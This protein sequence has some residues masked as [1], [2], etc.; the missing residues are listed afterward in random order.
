VIVYQSTKQ[1]FLY[2]SDNR[3]IEEV[4]EK[5]Y[6]QK[7]KRYASHGEFRAWRESLK[8]MAKVLRDEG[9]PPD[10][11]IGIEFGIPQSHKRIDFILS[12]FADDGSP[13]VV[14]VELKQWS[15]T[16]LRDFDGLIAAQR[17]GASYLDGPHPC[18]QAWSYAALLEGFNEAVYEGEV[19]LR[20]CAYLHNHEKDGVVNDSRYD[21]YM[22]RAPLFLKGEEELRRLREFVRKHVRKGDN[23]ELLFKIENGRIRPSKMLADS[24]VSMLRG[25]SDF[26]LIDEQKV[27]YEHALAAAEK[28]SPER[29]QV[30]LIKGGPGTGKSV[31]AIHLLAKL[32]KRGL[33]AKYVSRNAA[34]RAVYQAR[35]TG[36]FRR[37]VIANL[38]G[39]TSVF[40]D[41]EPNV[42]DVLIVD[43]A[44]RLNRKSGLYGNLGEDQIMEIMRS[45]SCSIFFVDDDQ[46]V[47]L[48]D[49]GNTDE[50]RRWAGLIGAEV[51]ELEL[52]SQ[53]R[54]NGSEGFLPW[55]DYLLGLREAAGDHFD[56]RTFEFQVVDSPSQLHELIQERNGANRSRVVAGYCWDW[57][58]K[59]DPGAFDIEIGEYR[60]RWNLTNDGSLWIIAPTSVSEVG[61]IHTCQGLEVDY[62]GVIVGRD[63]LYRSGKLVTAVENRSRMDRSVRGYKSALRSEPQKTA[64]LVDR[65]I[66]NTYRTLMTRGLKGCYIH[67]VDPETQGYFKSRLE[68]LDRMPEAK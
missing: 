68:S 26:V 4:V 64:E 46:A 14:I 5:A 62:I 40:H 24:L 18:Y 29:K 34:P 67:C 65:L 48:S 21:A 42:F 9:I 35:L 56:R 33:M 11:G 23:G 10:T 12:G 20:P 6:V 53:F 8:H 38:F 39:G 58:S 16:K 1:G 17:G 54:C 66:R 7:T 32:T 60:R 37:G 30:V 44:H 63:L 50:I 15:S 22:E 28:A 59:N 3:T 55:L 13:R 45:A 52:A 2:D 43:E 27:A 36:S 19:T 57:S 41:L 31:V 47:T 25:N 51:V 49:I 61:C